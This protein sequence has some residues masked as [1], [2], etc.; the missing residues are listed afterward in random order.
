MLM[1]LEALSKPYHGISFSFN[2]DK[3]WYITDDG[4]AANPVCVHADNKNGVKIKLQVSMREKPILRVSP[5]PQIKQDYF[6]LL[7]FEPVA[8][9]SLALEEVVAEKIRAANQRLKIRDIYDLSEI[10]GRALNR[11]KIRALA[12][13]KLW[14]TIGPNLN[15]EL[16]RSRIMDNEADYDIAD[17]TNLLRKD[18]KP[19]LEVIRRKVTEGFSF[20]ADMTGLEKTLADDNARRCRE[21]RNE[22]VAILGKT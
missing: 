15:Y 21:E 18:Q 10:A 4:I 20:I 17:L 5:L 2:R 19:D 7:P 6:G 11:E 16:F 22:I 14:D 3:D 8:I 9:P 12:V 1:M 13:L